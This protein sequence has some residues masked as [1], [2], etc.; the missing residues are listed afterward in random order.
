MCVCCLTNDFF[1]LKLDDES[2]PIDLS[3]PSGWKDRI[4]YVI[5]APVV[6]CM[7]YTAQDIKR[8]VSYM[9]CMVCPL[10][11]IQNYA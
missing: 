7:Y 8:P 3:W 4:V 6:F 11:I 2:E 1:S 9:Q 10:L 5:R